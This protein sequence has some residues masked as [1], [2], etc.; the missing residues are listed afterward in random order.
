[1]WMSVLRTQYIK[2]FDCIHFKSYLNKIKMIPI[3]F[4]NI[5]Y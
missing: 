1:M 2:C 3:V 5:L 4:K